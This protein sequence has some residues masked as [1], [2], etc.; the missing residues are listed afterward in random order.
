MLRQQTAQVVDWWIATLFHCH[1]TSIS[2]SFLN[3]F[4][5][6]RLL[7]TVRCNCSCAT[8]FCLHISITTHLFFLSYH[9]WRAES[10]QSAR[11]IITDQH[12]ATSG[13]G[14]LVQQELSYRKQIAHELRTQFVKGI[15]VTLK[16]TLRVTQGHWKRNQWTDHRR[17]I[18]RWI[19]SWPWN[20]GQRSLKI[21][22][23]NTMWKFGYGSLTFPTL[24]LTLGLGVKV[25]E[26]GAVR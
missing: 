22:E 16:S 14:P 24:T 7:T 11:V 21:I 5:S 23:S 1:F 10:H 4:L 9:Y 3:S 15:S 18:K 8:L 12:K 13:Q 17:V 20:V 25:T 2:N 26:N 19:L 6:I